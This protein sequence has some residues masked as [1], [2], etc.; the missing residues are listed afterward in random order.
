MVSF[1]NLHLDLVSLH[2][3]HFKFAMGIE[4]KSDRRSK[5]GRCT[6]QDWRRGSG[7]I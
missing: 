3:M 2:D 1:K 6:G 4:R 7:C 5:E